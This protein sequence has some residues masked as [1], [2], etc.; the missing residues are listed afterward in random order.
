VIPRRLADFV[1]LAAII[2]GVVLVAAALISSSGEDL[3]PTSIPEKTTDL[4][5]VQGELAENPME[6]NLVRER[7][8]EFATIAEAEAFLCHHLA[9]PRELPGWEL[10]HIR[11]Q[12]SQ[13]L[14]DTL[15]G[16]GEAYVIVDYADPE[17]PWRYIIFRHAVLPFND[18]LI[19]RAADE[20]IVVQGQ[21]GFLRRGGTAGE[22]VVA[23][24]DRDG[25]QF[26][27]T[28]VLDAEFRL[29]DFQAVLESVR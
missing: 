18:Q 22:V 11:A 4:V 21:E 25:M 17:R 2:A 15:Q 24:W 13:A 6:R 1:P 14:A 3:V 7:Q 28:T 16:F 26:R 19:R 23:S 12:R 10:K 8:E 5:C 29:P 27:V 20:S 9:Y